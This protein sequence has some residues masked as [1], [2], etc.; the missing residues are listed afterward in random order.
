MSKKTPFSKKRC[1]FWFV[2]ISAET[3]IFIAFTGLHCFGPKKLIDQNRWCAR[4]CAFF[5]L[6]DT[7]SVRQFLL[8]IHFF[9]FSYFW[10]TTLKKHYFYRVFWPLPFC[11]FVFVFF[12][13]LF[14]QHRKKKTKMQFSFRIPHFWHTQNFV[15]KKHFLAQC[16]TICVLNMPPKH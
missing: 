15:T 12:L 10:M 13:Y 14:L 16:D 11:V 4:K 6:P 5:S 1:H 8:N 2:A 9:D 3:T 7:N